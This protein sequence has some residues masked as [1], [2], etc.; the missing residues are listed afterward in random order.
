MIVFDESHAMSNA[1]GGKGARGAIAPSQQGRAGVRLQ[2]A[3]PQ[4]RIVYSS[5]TGAS[6]IDGLC[7]ASRLGLWGTPETP[8]PARADFVQA[9]DA[10]G[11]AALEVVARDCK[12][13][14]RYQARALSYT[15]VEVDIVEHVLTPSRRPSTTST[16][17]PSRSSTTTSGPPSRRPASTPAMSATP[18]PRP[19]PAP[20]SSSPSSASSRTC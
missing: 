3:L 11:V 6:T 16:R 1:A 8:F 7:Y 20:P 12:A 4:A 10:G 9:M 18:A 19:R 17:G 14:G 15:G 13:L 5:A 2:N